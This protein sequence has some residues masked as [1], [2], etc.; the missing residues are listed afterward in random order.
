MPVLFYHEHIL[1]QNC[2]APQGQ[3]MTST[4]ETPGKRQLRFHFASIAIAQDHHDAAGDRANK[5]LEWSE[6]CEFWYG[7]SIREE[8]FSHPSYHDTSPPI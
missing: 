1:S 5:P 8:F 3:A 7:P 2:N 6:V 4:M